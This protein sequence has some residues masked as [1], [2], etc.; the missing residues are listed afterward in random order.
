MPLLFNGI[1]F[2]YLFSVVVLCRCYCLC[3]CVLLLFF[4][5]TLLFSP[6]ELSSCRLNMRELNK[7]RGEL[8]LSDPAMALSSR[9]PG[10]RGHLRAK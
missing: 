9:P 7:V 5:N 8:G 1:S 4:E 10:L 3:K 6:S 2:I